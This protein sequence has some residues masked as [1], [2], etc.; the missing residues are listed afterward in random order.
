MSDQ[1][2]QA[3]ELAEMKAKLAAMESELVKNEEEKEQ[4]QERVAELEANKPTTGTAAKDAPII[5]LGKKKYAVLS[6]AIYGGK[7]YTRKELAEAKDICTKIVA[8]GTSIIV[9]A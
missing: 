4:L 5:T 9:P 1:K 8:K 7:K 2:D 3:Q 6:G